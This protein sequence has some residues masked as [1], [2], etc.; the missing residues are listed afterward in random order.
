MTHS[1][2]WK[3]IKIRFKIWE[4]LNFGEICDFPKP[5]GIIR[6][7]GWTS[8]DL[9][10]FWVLIWLL[11]RKFENHGYKS[12]PGINF[13]RIKIVNCKNRPYTPRVWCSYL[14]RTGFTLGESVFFWW[15]CLDRSD[16]NGFFCCSEC[17]HS[18]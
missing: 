4:Y 8:K 16:W 11:M 14:I 2:I 10:V 6:F 12:E 7:H 5:Q 1:F 13:L 18:T 3:K 17:G 15:K 9:A